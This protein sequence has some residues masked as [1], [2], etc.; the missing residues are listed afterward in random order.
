[1]QAAA[2]SRDYVAAQEL[3]ESLRAADRL[4][5]SDVEAFARAK[6]VEETA[7]A[8]AVMSTLPIDIIEHAMMQDRE[9][10]ILIVAKSIGLSWS[11]AKAVLLL[12]AGN[13]GMAAHSLEQC[14]ENFN[15][16]KRETAL[17]VIKFQQKR[18]EAQRS[19]AD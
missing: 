12:C 19:P 2:A 18:Q 16:L 14:R 11:T 3:V 7:V 10:T 1:L 9:E 8:L 6:K 17:Q 15:K 13:Q 4:T 5:E